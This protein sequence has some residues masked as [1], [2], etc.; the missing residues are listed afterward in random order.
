[1]TP[2]AR[3]D[4][5]GSVSFGGKSPSS[6]LFGLAAVLCV[7]GVAVADDTLGLDTDAPAQK[8]SSIQSRIYE[9]EAL[10][11][12]A[13]QAGQAIKVS[14]IEEKLRRTRASLATAKSEQR[15]W[16]AIQSQPAAARASLENLQLQELYALAMAQDARA[17]TDGKELDL[18][19]VVR[20]DGPARPDPATDTVRA[21]TFERPPLASPF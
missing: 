19:V 14:C 17:C 11:L 4:T 20:V 21:P 12:R 15:R 8:V 16:P 6:H 7:C 2:Y 1:L 5:V 9:I 3:L 13:A 10:R 18:S